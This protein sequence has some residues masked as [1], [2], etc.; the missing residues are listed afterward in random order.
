[1]V[2]SLFHISVLGCVLKVIIAD[3]FG[4]SRSNDQIISDWIGRFKEHES[5]AVAEIV[6]FTL[7]CAGCRFEVN[8]NDVEDPDSC[9]AKLREIQDKYQAVSFHYAQ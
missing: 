3:V 8:G 6:N 2:S 5:N 4:G 9:A 1:M 7:C